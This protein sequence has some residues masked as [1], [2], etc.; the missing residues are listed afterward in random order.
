MNYDDIINLPHYEP[1]QHTRMR[2]E[3]R[4]VQFMP[5]S[6]LN[7]FDEIILQTEDVVQYPFEINEPLS[8][9]ESIHDN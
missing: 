2:P 4:A 1:K 7:G 8:L 9:I 6:A 5:F 3:N